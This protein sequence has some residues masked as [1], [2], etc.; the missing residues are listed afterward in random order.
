MVFAELCS[1]FE[2]RALNAEKENAELKAKLEEMVLETNI[3]KE[4]K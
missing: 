1:S 3:L 4:K 2:E